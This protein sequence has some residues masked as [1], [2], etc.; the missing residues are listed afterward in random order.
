MIGKI[1]AILVG[2]N[3]AHRRF[4]RQILRD[5]SG[6]RLISLA[7]ARALGH[8]LRHRIVLLLARHRDDVLELREAAHRRT[9]SP[10]LLIA[11]ADGL[12]LGALSGMIM[13]FSGGVHKMAEGARVFA[14]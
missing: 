12:V 1:P 8:Q 7:L 3:S 2:R 5:S 13:C 11:T 4:H 10:L 6:G 9:K 14:G